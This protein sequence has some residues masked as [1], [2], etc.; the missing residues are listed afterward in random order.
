MAS[1]VENLIKS[2]TTNTSL[3]IYLQPIFIANGYEMKKEH[4][5]SNYWLV[6]LNLTCKDLNLSLLIKY[7]IS[8][9]YF[10]HWQTGKGNKSL[11]KYFTLQWSL[12]TMYLK[13]YTSFKKYR[14]IYLPF[15][16]H[17]RS[18]L[19]LV[20]DLLTSLISIFR[21]FPMTGRGGGPGGSF[22]LPDLCL[23]SER[24]SKQERQS[25]RTTRESIEAFSSC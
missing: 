12:V 11:S 15:A 24:R 22:P 25:T 8:F 2:L 6:I 23:Q 7:I 17:W 1:I 4:S 10:W 19:T 13:G 5:I 18:I 9:H 16:N 21:I 3:T 14:W 20:K